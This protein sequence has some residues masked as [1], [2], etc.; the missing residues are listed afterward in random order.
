MFAAAAPVNHQIKTCAAINPPHSW[1]DAFESRCK[2]LS[3]PVKYIFYIAEKAR[4][5]RKSMRAL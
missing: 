5:L 4:E 1:R 2:E 3:L